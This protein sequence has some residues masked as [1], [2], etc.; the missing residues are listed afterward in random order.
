MT[1]DPTVEETIDSVPTLTVAARRIRLLN[2]EAEERAPPMASA[3]AMQA[4]LFEI[5]D[6]A[7]R[8]PE[9][10]EL[11]QR[12]LQLTLSRTWY[13]ADE[14]VAL[15]DQL[16]WLLGVST[17][18]GADPAIAGTADRPVDEAPASA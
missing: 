14:V 1:H 16:D 6:E 18:A 9:A 15:A 17:P 13:S 3:E 11:V 8:N 4:R 7:L 5:Y 10:L 12:H 2:A